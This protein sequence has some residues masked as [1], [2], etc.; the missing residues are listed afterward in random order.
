MGKKEFEKIL[1]F[2]LTKN[3]GGTEGGEYKPQ[4]APRNAKVLYDNHRISF[5]FFADSAVNNSYES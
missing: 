5:A 1:E 2:P 4:S 3:I